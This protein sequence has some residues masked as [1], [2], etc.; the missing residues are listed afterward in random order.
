MQASQNKSVTRKALSPKRVDK[1]ENYL[2]L[3]AQ[4]SSEYFTPKSI[5]CI[6]K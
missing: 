2:V 1:L 5:L 6:D 4:G 3:T